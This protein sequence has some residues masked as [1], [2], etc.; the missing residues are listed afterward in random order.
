[1]KLSLSLA[2]ATLAA[3]A[4]LT[5]CSGSDG[6]IEVDAAQTPLTTA[7]TDALFTIRLVD[8]RSDGYAL[9]GLVVKATP[10]D[11][12]ALVIAGC[13]PND[14]NNNGKLEKGE[15]VVCTEGGTNILD[16][17]L[18]GKE[19]EVE[20]FATIEGEEEKIGDATWTPAAAK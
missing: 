11:K 2:F 3:L 16:A 15:T 14:A 18:S 9:A 8:A 20:L 19:V 6:G 13:Q 10:E 1:M 12:D 17:A 7:G 5:A 4:T